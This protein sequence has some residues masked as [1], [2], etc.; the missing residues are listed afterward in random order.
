V[1]LLF[2]DVN[3][4]EWNNGNKTAVLLRVIL[5]AVNGFCSHSP[6]KCSMNFWNESRKFHSRH[7]VLVES[8]KQ[9]SNDILV[10]VFVS[11]PDE[12]DFQKDGHSVLAGSTLQEILLSHKH[13]LTFAIGV[14]VKYIGMDT[15]SN[16]NRSDN[17]MNYIMIP[18]TFAVLAVVC[19]MA[20]CMHSVSKRRQKAINKERRKQMKLN[21]LKPSPVNDAE[22]RPKSTTGDGTTTVFQ[23]EIRKKKRKK[24]QQE[25]DESGD[26]S[27]E[28]KK[29]I[30]HGKHER[31]KETEQA[32]REPAVLGGQWDGGKRERV[33]TPIPPP[34]HTLKT[35][36]R[37]QRHKHTR[38]KKHKT[39]QLRERDEGYSEGSDTRQAAEQNSEDFLIRSLPRPR[40]LVP[41]QERTDT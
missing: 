19:C 9:E 5:D 34:H 3:L 26:R 18:I 15:S 10:K 39:S 33:P 27:R 38:K 24:H 29:K 41:L 36:L 13:N 21:K 28:K 22:G 2:E 17:K 40:K 16:N 6:S 20:Y 11:L 12:K 14:K 7:V 1:S 31:L 32:V 30:K 37:E 8:P 35:D 4:T 23:R 25:A